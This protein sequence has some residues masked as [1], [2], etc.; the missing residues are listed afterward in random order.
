MKPTPN[1]LEESSSDDEEL[2]ALAPYFAPT[3][4]EERLLFVKFNTNVRWLAI[5]PQLLNVRTLTQKHGAG[6]LKVAL[7]RVDLCIT[8]GEL[9]ASAADE[10]RDAVRRAADKEKKA[11]T[12]RKREEAQRV[13]DEKHVEECVQRARLAAEADVELARRRRARLGL[14]PKSPPK[15]QK[16]SQ[17]LA[18]PARSA[19]ASAVE[20][21]A[22]RAAA[23]PLAPHVSSGPRYRIKKIDTWR[24]R[25]PRAVSRNIM[26]P[27]AMYLSAEGGNGGGGG[28]GGGSV[29]SPTTGQAAAPVAAGQN[30]EA[31]LSALRAIL[32]RVGQN[33]DE[34]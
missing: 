14:S 2:L 20:T 17:P 3:T 18:T 12:L 11:A 32:A 16:K 1:E 13:R 19:T 15:R 29:R 7:A 8:T 30:S 28:G 9:A 33:S 10:A 24:P 21:V 5:V 6:S 22:R 31:A 34:S 27:A 23:P 26:E 25:E 4:E